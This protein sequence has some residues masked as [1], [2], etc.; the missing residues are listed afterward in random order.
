MPIV[1]GSVGSSRA[2]FSRS[3][4]VRARMSSFAGSTAAAKRRLASVY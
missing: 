4:C 2:R 1:D 3:F